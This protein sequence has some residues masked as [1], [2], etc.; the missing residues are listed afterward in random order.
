[1]RGPTAMAKGRVH[2]VNVEIKLTISVP[3]EFVADVSRNLMEL[4]EERGIGL[5][6]DADDDRHLKRLF[7]YGL[8]VRAFNAL[9]RAG[10]YTL[11][12]LARHTAND[13]RQVK[14]IGRHTFKNLRQAMRAAG[15]SFR[16]EI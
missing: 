15:V 16:K 7:D 10:C 2:V 6:I 11:G 13:V 3:E 12:D 5:R 4:F 1:M 8:G 14:N 9:T